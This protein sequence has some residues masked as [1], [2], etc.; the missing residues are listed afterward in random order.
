MV[1]LKCSHLSSS[2]DLRCHLQAHLK[3]LKHCLEKNPVIRPTSSASTAPGHH[4][5]Q[6]WRPPISLPTKRFQPVAE[7]PRTDVPGNANV[8]PTPEISYDEYD[9]DSERD[10]SA[11]MGDAEARAPISLSRMDFSLKQLPKQLWRPNFCTFNKWKRVWVAGFQENKHQPSIWGQ[12]RSKH[13]R[14]GP[15]YWM[16]AVVIFLTTFEKWPP[17]E[18]FV[19]AACRRRQWVQMVL[20]NWASEVREARMKG[21]RGNKRPATDLGERMRN[22]VRGKVPELRN[23][24]FVVVNHRVPNGNNDQ[25]FSNQLQALYPD[26]RH[27]EELMDFIEKNCGPKEPYCLNVLFKSNLTQEE[28]DEECKGL[29]TPRHMMNDPLYG[30]ISYSS[31]HS[32]AFKSKLGHNLKPL[33]VEMKPATGKDIAE[34]VMRPAKMI[35]TGLGT[36]SYAPLRISVPRLRKDPLKMQYWWIRQQVG[37]RLIVVLM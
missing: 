18:N 14:D 35:A 7:L 1:Y 37:K 3:C 8:P 34:H 20:K 24:T 2:Q 17:R 31:L 30:Q 5:G 33:F 4:P 15:L 28:L 26:A 11:D 25:T 21:S 23:T 32:N 29:Y 13:L 12:N 10:I 19:N 6:P 22:K 36:V 16:T 27:W 9:A